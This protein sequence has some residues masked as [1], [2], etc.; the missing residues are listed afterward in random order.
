[1]LNDPFSETPALGCNRSE[2]VESVLVRYGRIMLFGPPG[3]GKSTLAAE[4]AARLAVSGGGCG[5]IS[6]DPGSPAFG[7]PGAV[8]LGR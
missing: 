2:I 6:A 5:C 1:M 8:S 7:V 4:L 3:I